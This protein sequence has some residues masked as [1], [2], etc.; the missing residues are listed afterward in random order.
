M[1]E[2]VAKQIRPTE[3]WSYVLVHAQLIQAF[4]L[5]LNANTV[6]RIEC[7]L[8]CWCIYICSLLLWL[9][10][11]GLTVGTQR[12]WQFSICS[13]FRVWCMIGFQIYV[14]VLSHVLA[15]ILQ[16]FVILNNCSPVHCP[17]TKLNADSGFNVFLVSLFLK[18]HKQNYHVLKLFN[19]AFHGLIQ[20]IKYRHCP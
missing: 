7:S 19:L 20:C 4:F 12:H 15:I 3:C 1:N 2:Q 13:Q 14:S 6:H 10:K 8:V 16:I 5:P 18:I 11:K 9:S 17:G